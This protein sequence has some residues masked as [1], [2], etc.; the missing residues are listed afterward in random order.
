RGE[1]TLA[2]AGELFRT[3]RE[4][5][6]PKKAIELPKVQ[7]S[8][9]PQEPASAPAQVPAASQKLALSEKRDL[10]AQG[11]GK[12]HRDSAQVLQ[13]WKN[14]RAGV[15]SPAK[16]RHQRMF[17]LTD[18][19]LAQFDRLRDLLSHKLGTRDPQAVFL[20]LMK[21]GLHQMDPI[22]K[23]ERVQKRKE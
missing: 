4:A 20:W 7:P 23:E 10:L 12:T 11:L 14:E 15:V 8:L 17:A 13:S 9:L 18:E 16:P 1:L 5:E 21:Q 3:I 6:K 2:S 19:E 22:L